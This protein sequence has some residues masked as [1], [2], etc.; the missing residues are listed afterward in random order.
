MFLA[1]DG[2]VAGVIAVADPIKDTHAGGDRRA[3][4]PTGC[5]IVMAT[6]DGRTTAERRRASSSAST[7]C[8]AR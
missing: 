4:T 5:G 3:A 6:G 2:R 7:R 1:V 8:T